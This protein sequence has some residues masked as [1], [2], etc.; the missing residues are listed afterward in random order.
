MRIGSV[1]AIEGR[2][3]AMEGAH[4]VRMRIVV[5]EEH[6]APNFVMRVFDVEPGGHTPLH[7]HPFEHGVLVLS[8]RGEL[9]EEG[10]RE[11]LAPGDAVFV[12][13]GTVHQFR[14]A[15]DSPLRFLCVVPKT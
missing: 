9:V 10:R 15:Q 1:D 2:P 3:V 12:P 13:A 8:G 5:G 4:G 7:A 14:A 11:P 6:G